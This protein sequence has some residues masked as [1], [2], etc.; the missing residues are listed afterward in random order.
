MTAPDP[1]GVLAVILTLILLTVLVEFIDWLIKALRRPTT[2][3]PYN[4]PVTKL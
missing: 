4:R 3:H 2:R 1:I